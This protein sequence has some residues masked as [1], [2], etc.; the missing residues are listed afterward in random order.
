MLLIISSCSNNLVLSKCKL[1]QIIL[2]TEPDIESSIENLIR[3]IVALKLAPLTKTKDL[4]APCSLLVDDKLPLLL[5]LHAEYAKI[6][7]LEARIPHQLRI[8][9]YYFRILNFY[10]YETILLLVGGA[11]LCCVGLY[12]FSKVTFLNTCL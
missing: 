6:F 12:Y 8:S 9:I 10:N 1:N 2:F 5:W 4:E 7:E 11:S 3:H